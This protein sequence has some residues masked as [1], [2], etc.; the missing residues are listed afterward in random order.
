MTLK[1]VDGIWYNTNSDFEPDGDFLQRNADYF[2]A[3]AVAAD[4]LK[5]STVDGING[6][7]RENT[8][9]L[10]EKMLETLGDDAVMVLVNTLYFK[11]MWQEPFEPINT[12]D[13][14]FTL[15]GGGEV[16][17]PTMAQEYGAALYFE[18]DG[19]KGV[20]LPYEGGRYAYAAILPYV[21]V[22]EYVAALTGADFSELLQSASEQNVVLYLPKYEVKGSY[23]LNDTLKNMGLRMAFDPEKADFSAMGTASMNL[24]I[25]RVLQDTVFKLGEEGTEAAAATVVEIEDGCAAPDETQPIELRLDRPFVYALMDMETMTPLFLGVLENPAE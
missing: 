25:S 23:E 6:F 19:A 4:F 5:K 20:I 24:F 14:T 13:A 15:S 7:I 9:G 21:G 8:N 18:S 12:Y 11:G 17:T 1:A 2:D 16:K 22:S 10:I 3:A